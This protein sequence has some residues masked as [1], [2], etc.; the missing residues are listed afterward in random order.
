[1]TL[2]THQTQNIRKTWFLIAGFLVLVIGVG[3]FLSYYYGAPEILIIAVVIA[4]VQ[5]GISYW[6]SDKIALKVSGAKEASREKY[7]DL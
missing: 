5:V 3:Y 7:F 1:M 2:Y 4:F 6:K